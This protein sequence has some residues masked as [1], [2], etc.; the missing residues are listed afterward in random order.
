MVQV[1]T[2]GPGSLN[3][4]AGDRT[5]SPTNWYKDQDVNVI[6]L[7]AV[8]PEGS[9][10]QETVIRFHEVATCSFD[11]DYDAHFL[12]GYAPQFYSVSDGHEVSTNSLPMLTDE[13]RIHCILLKMKAPSFPLKPIP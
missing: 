3:L 10:A 7:H 2:A 12:G 5:H 11:A 13:L 4:Y 8:D 9:K 1:L 6:R